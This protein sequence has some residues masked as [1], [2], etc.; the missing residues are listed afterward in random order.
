MPFLDAFGIE[1]YMQKSDF[2]RCVKKLHF[3]GICGVSMSS[4]ARFCALSGKIVTGSDQN[5]CKIEDFIKLGIKVYEKHNPQNVHGADA[6]V[7]TSAVDFDNPEM[8]EAK[9]LKIPIIRRSQ[10]LGMIVGNCDKTVAVSGSHGKTTTT[11]MISNVLVKEKRRPLCFIGGEDL[12]LGNFV[13]GDKEVA[14]CEACEYKKNFLD[15]FPDIAVVLNIDNDH[16]DCYGSIDNEIVTF[17]D[18]V[19]NTLA[20]INADDKNS[21]KLF[22]GATVSFGIKNQACFSAFNLKKGDNGCYSFSVRAYSSYRGRIN[23][24]VLGK[25]NVYNA[26]ATIAVCEILGISFKAIKKSL[27]SF[28]GVK[29]RAENIGKIFGVEAFADYAHHP[30]EI[31]Q[32]IKTFCAE[33]NCIVVFQ[34]H[35]YS[36]TENLMDDFVSELSKCDSVIVYKTYSAREPF[37]KNGSSFKLYQNLCEYV[38]VDYAN[39]ICDLEKLIFEKIEKIDKILFLGAG[40]I[41]DVA[42]NMTKSQAKSKN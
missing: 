13:F 17:S 9:R 1:Y 25:H 34:P 11:A 15:I 30:S 40:D 20:V 23:L 2:F 16:L 18:F 39:N 14:V 36:R 29:R 21:L 6:V 42:K 28:Y 26:L 33:K 32:T 12:N 5:N 8:K 7:Y 31:K 22:H 4:L 3:I 38:D 41:Y 27:E 24:K 10:L 37:S 19:K 35:T